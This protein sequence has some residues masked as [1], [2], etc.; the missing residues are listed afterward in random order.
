MSDK[1]PSK[2]SG[3]K[4]LGR[5][6]GS[7][8]GNTSEGAFSK[9]TGSA[10]DVVEKLT[11][12]LPSQKDAGI[13]EGIVEAQSGTRIEASAL[14]ELNVPKDKRIWNLA[15][16]K[17]QPNPDQPRQEFAAESLQDLA[18]SIREKG[19]IQPILVHPNENGTFKII[20][21]E[22]RWRAAQLAGLK[23]VPAIL[24][25]SEEKEI[26]EL[27]L[28]ENIQRENLN[29]M[30]EAEAYSQLIE[31]YQMTQADLAQ[32]VGKDR[33]TVANIMRLLQLPPGLRK[34]VSQSELSMGQARALL[35]VQDPDEQM[36]L[37]CRAKDEQ[38]SVRILEK[39]AA[40]AKS[41]ANPSE[42]RR[43][44]RTIAALNLEEE[45]KKLL[46]AK[47]RL[48]Y[49]SGKGRI[50]IPFKNDGELNQIADT[51]R[52]SWRN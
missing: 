10:S 48:D 18:N 45:L 3:K 40:K 42:A 39:L 9:A 22:R 30:E 36:K 51:L 1:S 26:L 50:V 6:L 12:K 37:A 46:G 43:D 29:P 49:H 35:A 31:K 13:R 47:V 19:I 21:G 14:T 41:E 27:A 2:Q 8:L 17:V 28:I 23:E 38:L 25:A 20:A 11:E 15:I 33:A 16:E 52:D 44:A 4:G 34:M 32:K 5:G 24:K 7:L